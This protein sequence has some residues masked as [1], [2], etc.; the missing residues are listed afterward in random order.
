[1][2]PC[3]APILQPRYYMHFRTHMSLERNAPIER[4]VEPPYRGRVIAIPQIGSLHHR[5]RRAA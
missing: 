1:M 2:S 3:D 5:Y 4:E